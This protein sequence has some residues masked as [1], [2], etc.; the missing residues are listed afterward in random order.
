[1]S[2]QHV[3]IGKVIVVKTK[4][5]YR[6]ALVEPLL[7]SSDDGARW[8][9]AAQSLTIDFPGRGAVFWHNAPEGLEEGP[10]LQFEVEDRPG[11]GGKPYQDA[12]QVKN[13]REPF[14]I[15]DLRA[16]GSESAIRKLLT[17]EGVLL[18]NAPLTSRCLLRVDDERLVG[19]LV[20]ERL[21]GRRSWVLANGQDMSRLRC[22]RL[23]SNG[24][25]SIDLKGPRCLLRP[26]LSQWPSLGYVNW[27]PDEILARRVLKRLRKLD[28]VAV[29]SLGL[30]KK[31][32][33]AHINAVQKAGLLD[34]DLLESAFSARIRE[35]RGAVDRN[36][37]LIDE[38]AG[39]LFA[40]EPV[41]DELKKRKK[42]T[43]DAILA[44]QRRLVEEETAEE[45]ARLEKIRDEISS[46]E[47][48]LRL[49]NHSIEKTETEWRERE[50]SYTNEL[51]ERMRVL[52][53]RPDKFFADMA[54]I[55]AALAPPDH[56]TVRRA[57]NPI[58]DPPRDPGG[59]SAPLLE[60]M[61]TFFGS[62]AERLMAAGFSPLAGRSLHALFAVGLA[63]ILLGY[64][65][66]EILTIYADLVAGG[67]IHWIPVGGATYEPGDLLARFDP[68]S[69]SLAPH[70]GG[71][72]DLLLA[73]ER[74]EEVHV[75]VLEG[76]NRAPVESY[77][78]PLLYSLEDANLGRTPRGVPLAPGGVLPADD[79]YAAVE[80]VC[81]RPNVLL[82]L[83]PVFGSATLPVPP[84]LFRYA[85]ILDADA[86][87]PLELDDGDFP[88]PAADCGGMTRIS[89]SA[90][91]EWTEA[92]RRATRTEIPRPFRDAA[93]GIV[94]AR[95]ERDR[96]WRL[97]A[98]ARANEFNDGE[99]REFAFKMGLLP[100]LAANG[101][102]AESA[103][104]D[105]GLAMDEETAR[106]VDGAQRLTE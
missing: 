96:M 14:E 34:S 59:E 33:D 22:G 12:H 90:W 88:K 87:P 72:L 20:I 40:S 25:E 39:I 79:P 2:M 86:Y 64:D 103:A 48:E 5:D 69:R 93:A 51:I 3:Y 57:P 98:A 77:L 99:A 24:C 65:A 56:R 28:P 81:W 13:P 94:K 17:G 100:E 73:A 95:G 45:R 23:P 47:D 85:A 36:K 97:Y 84:S 4:E 60:E 7:K 32:F 44:E 101:R 89:R 16:I 92:T 41:Q 49:L 70:P 53:R 83:A 29:E 38:A 62:L 71:L 46:R 19:P 6:F 15:V 11:Y 37:N 82:A 61:E 68:G 80:S 75:V 52:A 30:T 1:M 10:I 31:T 67:R 54:I 43:H 21:A 42:A 74:S 35:I 26:H 58:S 78:P 76:F 104:A 9:D 106:I 66:H 50:A 8:T 102:A 55:R 18:V 105:L 27:E 91:R 63:P